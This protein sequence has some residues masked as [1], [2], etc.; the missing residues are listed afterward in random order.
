[1][2]KK[3]V[4]ILLV[5][6][7]MIAGALVSMANEDEDVTY[8]NTIVNDISDNLDVSARGQNVEYSHEA[9]IEKYS[10][11]FFDVDSKTDKEYI[12]E[13]HIKI[14]EDGATKDDIQDYD[15]YVTLSDTVY[16]ETG[17]TIVV[18]VFVQMGDTF[19]LLG[20]PAEFNAWCMEPIKLDLPNVGK[21]NP[22][23]IRII[24][25]PKNSYNE[26]SLDNIQIY[27][28]EVIIIDYDLKGTLKTMQG[29]LELY[30]IIPK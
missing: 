20:E 6:S 19:E 23:C 29:I 3:I 4:F 21:D 9:V 15:L 16:L 1:M 18:M 5:L 2:L 30:N 12:I 8:N 25:F 26:L 24:A 22:N 27:D 7:F 14:K 10:S 28:T 17:N 11:L 13:E